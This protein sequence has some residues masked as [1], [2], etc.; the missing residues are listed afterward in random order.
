[1]LSPIDELLVTSP[2][3]RRELGV[4]LGTHACLDGSDAVTRAARPG[5]SLGAIAVSNEAGAGASTVRPS[6]N[7][8]MS[9]A[10]AAAMPG[11]NQDASTSTV[12][13][14]ARSSA[15]SYCAMTRATNAF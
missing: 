3:L 8:A 7:P 11:R 10:A 13:T 9:A 14:V 12:G 15:R 4:D 6:R 1:M 5:P 2:L